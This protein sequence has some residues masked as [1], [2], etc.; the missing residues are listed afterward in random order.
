MMGFLTHAWLWKN[1]LCIFRSFLEIRNVV[2]L[3]WRVYDKKMNR[4]WVRLFMIWWFFVPGLVDWGLLLIGEWFFPDGKA[5]WK[6]QDFESWDL[7]L[8]WCISAIFCRTFLMEKGKWLSL[9][10]VRLE[11]RLK[12]MPTTTWNL[13]T[14][15]LYRKCLEITKHPIHPPIYPSK[16]LAVY[17]R[18]FGGSLASWR[19]IRSTLGWKIL[20]PFQK[21]LPVK[22]PRGLN[23]WS[24]WVTSEPLRLMVQKSGW[25]HLL[26]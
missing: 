2:K 12:N 26:C 1:K 22:S 10:R 17:I 6:S 4:S 14:T 24:V 18:P 11:L 15:S 23:A 7:M 20:Q 9:C 3:F 8:A 19:F 5:F 16:H 21:N 13:I 25:F